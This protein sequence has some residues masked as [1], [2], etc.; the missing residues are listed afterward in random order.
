MEGQQVWELV[1]LL[2]GQVRAVPG[3]V[4]GFD[5]VAAFASAEALGIPLRPVAEL[6]PHIEI[7]MVTRFN[8]K[9]S[10]D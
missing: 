9:A 5:M 3:A 7:A 6:L 2:G 4:I 8:A 1:G 10:D